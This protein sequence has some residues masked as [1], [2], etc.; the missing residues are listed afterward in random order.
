MGNRVGTRQRLRRKTP[1]LLSLG[2]VVAALTAGAALTQEGGGLVLTLG[3]HQ[4]VSLVDNPGLDIPSTGSSARFDTR[5]SFG[6]VSETP[7]NRLAFNLG[8]VLRGEDGGSGFGFSL[9][10]PSAELAYTRSGPSSSLTLSAFLRESDLGEGLTLIEGTDGNPPVLTFE[11]G[12][13]RTKGVRLAYSWGEGAPL[14][15]TLRAGISDT[16]YHDTTDPDLLDNRTVT[17]GAGFRFALNEV[18]E[19]T[20]NLDHRRYDEDGPTAAEDSTTLS[21]GI[22]RT[23]PRGSLNVKLSTSDNED[24]SR[25]G[26]SFGRVFD[27]PR[28]SLSFE[29][30]MTEATGSGVDITGSLNWRQDLPNGGLLAGLKRA[31]ANDTDNQETLVTSLSLGMTQELAPRLSLNLGA[32]WTQSEKQATGL[33]TDTTSLDASVSYALTEDWAMNFGASHKVKDEDGVGSTDSTSVFVSLG[34]TFEWRP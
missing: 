1:Q 27:L 15:G 28:G 20:V 22:V 10:N 3:V 18:T 21:A 12:S 29:L 17:V 5:L 9:D 2:G 24:G 26:L 33:A 32:S 13:A 6:V 7:K 19:A 8:A 25:S 34:R 16:D 11:D 4:R 31:V 23:L 30:G 14:G